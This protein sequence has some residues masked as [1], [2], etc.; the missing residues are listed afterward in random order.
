VRIA[1]IMAAGL[2]LTACGG[3]GGSGAAS[4]SPTPGVAT[5]IT[6]T[7]PAFTDGQMIPRQYTCR[8]DG[9]APDVAWTGVPSGAASV[10][11]VVFDPDAGSSGFVH[12]V[13]YDLPAADGQLLAGTAPAGARE[14]DNGAGRPGWTA[15]CPPSGTHHYQFTVY[16][17]SDRPS[18][19]STQDVIESITR[20]A[21]AKGELTGLVASG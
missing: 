8:G 11:L 21:T 6:V 2:V 10:A 1:W 20:L 5:S 19:D 13:V 18:G 12:W 9:A 16:A 3:G 7:S 4:S 17:L 15:P 14:A